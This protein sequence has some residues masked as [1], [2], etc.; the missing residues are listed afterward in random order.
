[1]VNTLRKE[2]KKDMDEVGISGKLVRPDGIEEYWWNGVNYHNVVPEQLIDA[3]LEAT[4]KNNKKVEDKE[5][6]KV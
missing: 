1:M 2:V 6:E 3:E 5:N 4:S